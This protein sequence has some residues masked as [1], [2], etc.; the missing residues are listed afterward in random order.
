MRFMGADGQ[1]KKNKGGNTSE[2]PSEH[3]SHQL[4]AGR[5][6]DGAK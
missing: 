2:A 4:Q 6:V 1:E 3:L 5:G